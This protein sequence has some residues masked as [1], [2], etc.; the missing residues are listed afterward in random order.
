MIVDDG[1]IRL[2]VYDG[3]DRVAPVELTLRR[4]EQFGQLLAAALHRLPA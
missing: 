4:A 2:A 1:L 3:A